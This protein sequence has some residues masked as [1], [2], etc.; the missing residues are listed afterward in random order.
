[1]TRDREVLE[2]V[3]ASL[4]RQRRENGGRLL[5]G[6]LRDAHELLGVPK[7]TLSRWSTS[8]LP[9][10][11]RPMPRYSLLEDEEALAIV[12]EVNESRAAAHRRLVSMR[13]DNVPS[14]RTLQRSFRRDL[15]RGHQHAVERGDA[16]W[17]SHVPVERYEPEFRNQ[18]WQADHT[19][20]EVLV[21][22]PGKN[23]RAA[24]PW[25]TTFIDCYSRGIMG[26][27]LSLQPNQGHVLAALGSAVR[28]YPHRGP[29]CGVPA[30]VT[31]D[32]GLE[33]VAHAVI[34]ALVLMRVTA[35]PTLPRHPQ[36]NGKIERLHQTITKEFLADLPGYLDG[37]KD[38][39]KR[40]LA[41]AF[42]LPLD[43]FVARLAAW[44]DQYNL[45]RPHTALDGQTPAEVFAS[46][47]TPLAIA[48]E[49]LLRRYLLKGETRVVTRGVLGYLK[50]E[51]IGPGL[52]EGEKVE[53]RVDPNDLR[54]IEVYRSH[55]HVCTATMKRVA[56][57]QQRDAWIAYN[58][59]EA[60][61]HTKARSRARRQAR[62]RYK[63][64]VDGAGSVETTTAPAGVALPDAQQRRRNAR[65]RMLDKIQ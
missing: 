31:T 19:C 35:M 16:G 12:Y 55:E 42:V 18:H 26:Y 8:G 41:G 37:S 48:P 11:R 20:L 24:R 54:T 34:E 65:Q 5:D 9:K 27:S 53:I 15:G 32:R 60:E 47:P 2:A 33:F 3:V 13:P 40:P 51:Y 39:E 4:Q 52:R 49:E 28:L 46:D 44:I 64:I 58:E 17:R 50:E 22:P 57:E 45:E 7:S 6:A 23:R 36:N 43:E 14:K 30:W 10:P 56:T 25:L 38:L 29:F 59:G 63:A 61:S 62:R 21:Q 1:M